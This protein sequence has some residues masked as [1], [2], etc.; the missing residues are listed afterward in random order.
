MRGPLLNIAGERYG[1]VTVLHEV[2][3]GSY[4]R[5]WACRCDC[6][7]EFVAGQASL[8]RGGTKTCG[9]K[10]KGKHNLANKPEYRIW[11]AMRMRCQDPNNISYSNYGG[12]G[13]AVCP[14]WDMSVAAFYADMGP[15]PSPRHWIERINGDLGYSPGNCIWVLPKVQARNKRT[16]RTIC[17]GGKSQCLAAWAEE[18]G[19]A[20]TA[21]R[22]RIDG[23]WDIEK[24]LT[25]PTVRSLKLLTFEGVTDSIAG[26]ARR[27]G[28]PYLC[29]RARL[30]AGWPLSR[31]ITEP[32]HKEF[33]NNQRTSGV[34]CQ[35]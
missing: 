33:S 8:R 35:L 24:A 11:I 17:F 32:L 29:F 22:A 19:I 2:E 15:R 23:G 14:E 10:K 31:A 12:R 25:Y 6:G 18:K 13:I 16:N 34:N 9:C 20:F 3:P 30:L 21:L 1:I 4:D 27:A 26:W 28:L 7:R 5:L